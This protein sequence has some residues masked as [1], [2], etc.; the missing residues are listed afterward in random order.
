MLIM[1]YINMQWKHFTPRLPTG[2]L[3]S[4]VFDIYRQVLH[5]GY[6]K[7]RDLQLNIKKIE[8]FQSVDVIFASSQVYYDMSPAV[9]KWEKKVVVRKFTNVLYRRLSHKLQN[10]VVIV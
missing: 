10:S 7:P 1:H 2:I 5:Y 6:I 8:F 4:S 9:Q 3:H